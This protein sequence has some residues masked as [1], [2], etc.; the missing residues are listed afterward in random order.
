MSQGTWPRVIHLALRHSCCVFFCQSTEVWTL[1]PNKST[2]LFWLFEH[3]SL[4]PST[5]LCL[6]GKKRQFFKLC[7]KDQV[8]TVL[9]HVSKQ[10]SKRIY[11]KKKCVENCC[12]IILFN[13]KNAKK[14]KNIAETF[15]GLHGIV[16]QGRQP[17][18]PA[19]V[20]SSVQPNGLVETMGKQRHAPG[21]K[22]P[23]SLPAASRRSKLVSF[24]WGGAFFKD[25]GCKITIFRF[26]WDVRYRRL[27]RSNSLR[28][29]A[30]RQSDQNVER[31][32]HAYPLGHRGIIT[33]LDL[34]V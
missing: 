24:F 7:A 11:L 30:A 6:A 19:A 14:Q 25:I 29:Q 18:R 12:A 16:C 33:S 8:T 3:S 21:R 9:Q 5:T 13:Q 1:K 17:R 31:S 27:S 4:C 26:C 34:P 23:T 22:G 2:D 28:T 15:Y 20:G 10:C 32:Q